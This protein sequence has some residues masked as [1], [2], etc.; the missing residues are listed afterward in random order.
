MNYPIQLSISPSLG[1]ELA[2]SHV[3]PLAAQGENAALNLPLDLFLLV[4]ETIPGLIVLESRH[5]LN[6]PDAFLA[7]PIIPAL[8]FREPLSCEPHAEI[9]T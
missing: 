4:L 1:F 8:R 9:V 3:H 7:L 2:I 6:R 5:A